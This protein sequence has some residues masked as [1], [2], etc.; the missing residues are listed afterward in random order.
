MGEEI[1]WDP[2]AVQKLGKD[3]IQ[4]DGAT[5]KQAK[6][7]ADA[8]NI[9]HTA[10]GIVGFGLSSVHAIARNFYIQDAD[11]KYRSLQQIESGLRQVADKQRAAEE[12]SGGGLN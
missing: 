1:Q 4:Q 7:A 8:I 6:A 10:W 11:S 2:E 3:L 5:I 9:G 12:A